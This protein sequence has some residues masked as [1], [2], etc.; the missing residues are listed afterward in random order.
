MVKTKPSCYPEGNESN[1][2]TV[3]HKGQA[4]KKNSYQGK[5]IWTKTLF[6]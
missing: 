1:N 4:P 5:H 6:Q 2:S 3:N